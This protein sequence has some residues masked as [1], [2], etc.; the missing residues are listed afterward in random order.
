VD[1]EVRYIFLL[2]LLKLKISAR[3]SGKMLDLCQVCQT[4]G[5]CARSVRIVEKFWR[6]AM[7]ATPRSRRASLDGLKRAK[8]AFENRYTSQQACATSVGCSRQVVGQFLHREPVEAGLFEK[9][10]KDL[11]LDWQEIVDDLDALV[12]EVRDKV[13]GSIQSRCG[14]MRVLDMEQPIT[15]DSI[16]TRVNILDRIPHNQRFSIDELINLYDPQ[17]FNRFRLGKAR[18]ERIPAIEAVESH[19]KLMVLGGPGVGK[20]TFLKWL[21]LQC[22]EGK[23]FADRVPFFITLKIFAETAGEPDLLS[24]IANQLRDNG[25]ENERNVG[26]RILLAGRAIVLLDGLDE[27]RA[28]DHDRVL[29]TIRQMEETFYA[30]KFVITCRIAAKEYTFERFIEVE[31]APFNDDQIANFARSWFQS[32]NLINAERFLEEL[33]ISPGLNEL[34]RN[35]LLLTLLCLVFKEGG[36]FPAN[37]SEL[38]KEGLDILLR[39]WDATRDIQR[40]QID[41]EANVYSQLSLKRKEDLLS[42]I[43][44]NTFERRDYFFQQN[45]VEGQIQEYIRNL[46]HVNTEQE[47]LEIDSR[48]ILQEIAAHHGLLV[49]RARGIYSFSHLTFQEYF[50]ALWIKEKANGYFSNILVRYIT[51]KQWREVFLLTVGMLSNAGSLLQEIKQKIDCLLASDEMLQRFLQWVEQ[52]SSSTNDNYKLPAVRAFYLAQAHTHPFAQRHTHPLDFALDLARSLDPNLD[53]DLARALAFARA[54]ARVGA[55]A[56]SPANALALDLVLSNALASALDLNG[57]STPD[58]VLVS[59]LNL[60]LALALEI[61]TTDLSRSLQQ[62]KDRLP[63][64]FLDNLDNFRTWWKRNGEEW[65]EELRT[66]MIRHRNVGQ[67]WQF[68]QSKLKLIQQYYD[69][70][71][72]LVDCLESDCYVSR[73]VREEIVNSLLLPLNF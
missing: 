34:A 56:H 32:N 72:L 25:I 52:K 18:G 11:N 19:H 49:E 39:T 29:R 50:T 38:Y 61:E 5:M 73:E 8:S 6:Q 60:D 66:I 46:P 22:D 54:G 2:S 17:D 27:V 1:L 35:P 59:A 9:I 63:A 23:V 28:Q 14:M 65:S 16:Y 30:S 10:C 41:P 51:D 31:V 68:S 40:Q 44:Y 37:R 64:S 71:K 55:L 13:S 42:Q 36:R 43:A 47:N 57:S 26:E 21:A 62:M 53:F 24:F 67:N 48:N 33:E 69:A 20:T 3:L 4:C 12:E 58:I 7:S 45:F 70:S 15:I